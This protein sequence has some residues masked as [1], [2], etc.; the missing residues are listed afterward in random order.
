MQLYFK[1]PDAEMQRGTADI[2]QPG[3]SKTHKQQTPRSQQDLYDCSQRWNTD[4]FLPEFLMRLILQKL[5]FC[6]AESGEDFPSGEMGVWHFASV[7]LIAHFPPRRAGVAT[8]RQRSSLADAWHVPVPSPRPFLP[9]PL[10]PPLP[11]LYL[12]S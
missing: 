11:S 4:C 10:P 9:P 3:W 1:K 7:A 12:V 2:F 8:S 6:R 5:R